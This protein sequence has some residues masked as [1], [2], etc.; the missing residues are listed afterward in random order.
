MM[1]PLAAFMVIFMVFFG[2]SLV[3]LH[4]GRN[5]QVRVGAARRRLIFGGLTEPLASALPCGAA[6]REQLER[7][8]RHAGHYH[9]DALTEF[10][11]LR[12]AL[13][14]GWVAL[15]VTFLALGTEPGDG[16]LLPTLLVGAVGLVI[17]YTLPRLMLEAMA[18]STPA[19]A[20]LLSA[21]TSAL[22]QLCSLCLRPY[23]VPF[24]IARAR[25][26]L[27]TLRPSVY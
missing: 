14:L 21:S 7:F 5:Q 22:C 10:L 12:S 11:A 20:S 24:S 1:V 25:R 18:K 15:I 4:S 17:C 16:L 13:V 8:L 2:A 27:R 3:F 9:R 19:S 6:K 26:V 23:L